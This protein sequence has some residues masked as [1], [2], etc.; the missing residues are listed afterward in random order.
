MTE[1]EYH[2]VGLGLL[3]WESRRGLGFQFGG[4]DDFPVLG[5]LGT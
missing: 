5:R 1:H 4:V 3:Q 2:E